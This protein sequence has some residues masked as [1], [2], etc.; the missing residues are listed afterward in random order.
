MLEWLFGPRTH[1]DADGVSLGAELVAFDVIVDALVAEDGVALVL[2][3]GTRRLAAVRAPERPAFVAAVLA[4]LPP[5]ANASP[6][7]TSPRRS[8]APHEGRHVRRK[9]RQTSAQPM[10]LRWPRGLS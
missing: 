10:P 7:R 3:D 6:Y 2:A 9:L 5:L 4:S 8:D 1:I